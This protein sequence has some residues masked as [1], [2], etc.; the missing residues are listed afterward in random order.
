MK[1]KML[2]AAVA[3]LVMAGAAQASVSTGVTPVIPAASFSVNLAGSS[4]QDKAITEILSSDVCSSLV[5]F[6]DNYGG[7]ST[8]SS[9]WGGR[10]AAY[11]CTINPSSTL[12]K[13]YGVAGDS[14]V[15]NKRSAGGSGYGI[16]PLVDNAAGT[17]ATQFAVNF[18]QVKAAN[19]TMQDTSGTKLILG[20]GTT[21]AFTTYGCT[22]SETIGTTAGTNTF[23]AIPDAGIADTNPDLYFGANQVLDFGTSPDATDIATLNVTSAAALVFG[24]PVTYDLYQALQVAQGLV[25]GGCTLGAYAS[26]SAV[27]GCM[28]SL[29]RNQLAA[30]VSGNVQ[31]W[32]QLQF[33][34]TDLITAAK[35]GGVAVPGDNF[36]HYCQ[37]TSG[38]GSAAITYAKLLNNPCNANAVSPA[39]S[40]VKGPKVAAMYETVDMEQCLDD[41]QNGTSTAKDY[42]TKGTVNAGVK[43]WGLGQISADKNVY[44]SSNI[45]NGYPTGYSRGYRFIKIDNVSPTLQNTFNGAYPFW[46]QSSWVVS[47]GANAPT[48]NVA[49]TITLLQKNATTGKYLQYT[50]AG[51]QFGTSG[52]L[53][54]P[55][56]NAVTATLTASNPVIPFTHPAGDN[57]A[58]PTPF[59][60]SETLTVK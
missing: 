12:A 14:F 13:T 48:G 30:L 4:A 52:Y 38:S 59:T 55:D 51:Q 16:M 26:A 40:Q 10:W 3:G 15:I 39:T 58:V 43:A 46:A 17:G 31:T 33:G 49:N 34:G 11:Y 27:D 54:L 53:G 8:S 32:S 60:P 24:V 44:S 36:V 22:A 28:P 19:C 41:L 5:I 42:V 20:N 1:L 56:N 7:T 29:S 45:T 6:K 2:S 23:Q 57:C 35:A 21:S 18:M 47:N 50:A 25:A 9:N 37:R